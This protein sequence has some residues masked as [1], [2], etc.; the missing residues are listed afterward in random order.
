MA[1]EGSW[2]RISVKAF[3]AALY[4]N[5][6]SIATARSKAGCTFASHDVANLTVPSFPRPDSSASWDCAAIGARNRDAQSKGRRRILIVFLRG[7]AAGGANTL[8]LP[9][10]P[11]NGA[12]IPDAA[13]AAAVR[14]PISRSVRS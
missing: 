7:G 13:S 14:D 12:V 6:W 9:G 3:S 1:H 5:E 2:S 11:R 4:Q 8:R 10:Q